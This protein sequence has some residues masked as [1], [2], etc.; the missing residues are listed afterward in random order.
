MKNKFKNKCLSELRFK[1]NKSISKSR[2]NLNIVKNNKKIKIKYRNNHNKMNLYNNNKLI[3][4]NSKKINN[5]IK[6][7]SKNKIKMNKLTQ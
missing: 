4:K 5:K 3:K 1:N 2:N 7:H 6:N